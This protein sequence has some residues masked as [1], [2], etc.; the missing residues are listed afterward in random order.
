MTPFETVIIVNISNIK[1]ITLCHVHD[2]SMNVYSLNA[3]VMHK[4]TNFHKYSVN[5]G[6]IHVHVPWDPQSIK[7]QENLHK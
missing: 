4:F 5:D 6:E 7:E 2:R 1:D 3:S